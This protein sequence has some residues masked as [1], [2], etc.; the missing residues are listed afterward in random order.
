MS[1]CFGSS[2]KLSAKEYTN[3]RKNINLFCDV[4]NKFIAN[5]YKAIGTDNACVNDSGIFVKFNSQNDQL[6][7]K[8]GYEYFLSDTRQDLSQNYIG[9]QTKDH[10]CDIFDNIVNNT[11]ISNN[12]TYHS[13]I[14]TIA[15]AGDTAQS[16][17]VDSSGIYVNR[18]AEIDSGIAPTGTNEF[19][20]GKKI[21]YQNCGEDLPI[22]ASGRMQIVRASELPPPLISSFEIIIV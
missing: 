15:P 1:R 21:I 19:P 9:Q 12:Y 16:L 4:R 20:N 8:K 11:D 3:K 10:F 5:G 17:I 13:T 7:I 14:L 22:R 18:Y 6:Q 2:S